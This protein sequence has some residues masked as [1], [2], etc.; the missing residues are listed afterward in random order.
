VS[1]RFEAS[2]EFRKLLVGDERPSLLQIALEIARDAYPEL[3]PG[4]YVAEV[5]ALA[6]RVRARCGPRAKPR[7]VLGQINWAL[8]V[9]DGYEG[10]RE[11]YF[12]PRN[13]YLNEVIDRK[14]GIPISLSVL[15]FS[16]GERLGIPLA[17][18]NIPA[19]FMLRFDEGGKEVFIDPFYAG[20]FLDRRACE[21]RVAELTRSPVALSDTQFAPCSVRVVVARM[22][23]NLK[24]IYLGTNDYASALPVQRR[25]AAIE[26]GD[27]VEQRDL[28]MICLQADQPG[29]AI[30]PLAAYLSIK[31]D[32]EDAELV[33]SLLNAARRMVAQWN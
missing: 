9:E 33:T 13:S 6:G 5:E 27:A 4:R 3:E 11:N 29:E 26:R 32:A 14:K 8:F 7:K 2:P 16:L 24:A 22:L 30:D 1:A 10:N 31:P 20:E 12:D 23:R 19:H 21:R 17:G 25:L 15:Y 28:G 18:V